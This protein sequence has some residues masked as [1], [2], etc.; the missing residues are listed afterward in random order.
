MKLQR[1]D[2]S[3]IAVVGIVILALF[4]SPQARAQVKLE[5]KYPEGTI[6][7]DD[8]AKLKKDLTAYLKEVRSYIDS[9]PK[10]DF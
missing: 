10:S 6:C 1:A 5:Y 4:G 2:R 7:D 8:V 9:L 3:R